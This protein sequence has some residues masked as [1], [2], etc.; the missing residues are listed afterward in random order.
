M[1]KQ[2]RKLREF[3]RRKVHNLLNESSGTDG[4]SSEKAIRKEVRS[5][6]HELLAESNGN[7]KTL[8]EGVMGMADMPAVN[9]ANSFSKQG[10]ENFSYDPNAVSQMAKRDRQS[11]GASTQS[12]TLRSDSDLKQDQDYQT[13]PNKTGYDS[14]QGESE[15]VIFENQE[16]G[17][18][19]SLWIEGN[20]L[21]CE[22][23]SKSKGSQKTKLSEERTREILE[24][25]LNDNF[26][27]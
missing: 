21:V 19:A 17:D 7:Q 27:M 5:V 25:I 16:S 14:S 18:R 9:P 11:A 8:N 6:I 26:Q 1:E 2:E 23:E 4:G 24:K 20:Q 13:G 10:K 12:N 3:I 15:K 22:Y